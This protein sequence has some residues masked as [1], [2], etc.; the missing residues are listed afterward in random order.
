[1][2]RSFRHILTLLLCLSMALTLGACSDEG[3]HVTKRTTTLGGLVDITAYGK[4]AEDGIRDAQAALASVDSMVDSFNE[5]S[6]VYAVNHSGG[7]PVVVTAQV[8]SM[9][10]TAR[11]VSK[12]TDGAL[13][14]TVYPLM[15]AWG[16]LSGNY[17]VPEEDTIAE[18]LTHIGMSRINLTADQESGDYML[19]LPADTQITLDCAARGAATNAAISALRARGVKSAVIDMGGNVQTLGLKPD[20]SKWNIAIMDPNDRNAYI[21]YLSV[22]ETAVVTASPSELNFTQRGALYH[23]IMNPATG[24]P[25]STSL[26]SVTIVCADGQ[27][28][29]C[30]STAMFVCGERRALQYWRD[31]GGFEMLLITQDGRIVCTQGLYGLFTQSGGDYEVKY[32]R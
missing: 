18:V 4:N 5:N 27:M 25:A 26:R 30:L 7:Q 20:G 29:D 9:I 13:D 22:G 14:L 28:A 17:T 15:D 11:T 8:A 32:V 16:F 31:Y 12:Q 1:M 23:H 21:G 2:K 10:E 24:M 19:Q 6:R 3:R